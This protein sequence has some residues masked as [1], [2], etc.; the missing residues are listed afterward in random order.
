MRARSLIALLAL[1]LTGCLSSGCCGGETAL[2]LRN[3][4]RLN[5]YPATAPGARLI[6][7]PPTYYE[8][9]LAAPAGDPCAPGSA[10]ALPLG[11]RR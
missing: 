10:G 8:P 5:Q 7:G 1:A 6:Q 2:E 4:V 11:Y 3:P 9:R